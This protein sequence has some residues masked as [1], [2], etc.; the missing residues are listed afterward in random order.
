MPTQRADTTS[1]HQ[2]P[3]VCSKISMALTGQSC[4]RQGRRQEQWDWGRHE[5]R[6]QEWAQTLRQLVLCNDGRWGWRGGGQQLVRPWRSLVARQHA[7]DWATDNDYCHNYPGANQAQTLWPLWHSVK[8]SEQ[9]Y[10][11]CSLARMK[12]GCMMMPATS[13]ALWMHSIT[14]LWAGPEPGQG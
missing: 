2:S 1:L 13:P 5:S 8:W 4:P 9:Y 10:Q 11:G 12:C 7:L 3:Y 14:K 6:T